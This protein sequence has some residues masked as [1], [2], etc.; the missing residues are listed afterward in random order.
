MYAVPVLLTLAILIALVYLPKIRRPALWLLLSLVAVCAIGGGVYLL[1]ERHDRRKEERAQAVELS[2]LVDHVI[3]TP[4]DCKSKLFT[5]IQDAFYKDPLAAAK[6][7]ALGQPIPKDAQYGSGNGG[8]TGT[9][10]KARDEWDTFLC[11]EEVEK[12]MTFIKEHEYELNTFIRKNQRDPRVPAVQGALFANGREY[13][14]TCKDWIEEKSD[15][16]VL[17]QHGCK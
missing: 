7:R 1:K 12:I 11:E 3:G 2:Y 9:K 8:A 6:A 14:K 13:E 15:D 16:Y 10:P 17:H 4:S 5:G